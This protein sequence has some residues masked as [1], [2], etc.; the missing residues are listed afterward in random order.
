VPLPARGREVRE[1]GLTLPP[2][3]LPMFRGTRPRKQWRYVG[4]YS[5]EVMLCTGDARIGPVRRRWQS[6]ALPDGS[7]HEG[8]GVAVEL[9]LREG[10]GVETA[11]PAGAAYTWTRKQALVPARGTVRYDGHELALD[12]V[13]FVDESAGYHERHTVWKWSAGNGRATDG[14][15]VAW[16]LVTGVHDA[17]GASERTVWVEGEPTEV[18]PARFAGD[19]AWVEAEGARLDFTEWCARSED[20]NLGLLRNSYRQPFGTFAG[21]LP[22]GIE[23][24]EGY[25][26][27][28][29]HDVHW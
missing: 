11:S 28:E 22:G 8:A 18:G 12:G 6:V 10:P 13:A 5:A 15:S 23:L 14:R 24:V 19:L 20:T 25:G 4:F 26:V 29:S 3:R 27:M 9:T 16:N 21:T 1:L 7:L 2:E 17:P